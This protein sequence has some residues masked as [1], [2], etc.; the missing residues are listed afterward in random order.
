[1]ST[2][3]GIARCAFCNQAFS[4][5]SFQAHGADAMDA[6]TTIVT[7]HIRASS[8]V[9][10]TQNILAGAFVIIAGLCVLFAPDGRALAA[11]IVALAFLVV[12][13]G[14]AGFANLRVRI[15][16]VELNASGQQL[17]VTKRQ[18]SPP[19]ITSKMPSAQKS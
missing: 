19:K 8:R 2:G 7:E 9:K 12:G 4:D 17:P 13:A 11:E 3:D 5:A 16:H 6:Q 18:K 14:I 10:L 15:P 1:V